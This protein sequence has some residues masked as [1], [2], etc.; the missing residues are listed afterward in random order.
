MDKILLSKSALDRY[1]FIG[2]IFCSLSYIFCILNENRQI[3]FANDVMMKSLGVDHVDLVLGKRFG[4]SFKCI[5][6]A[7]EVG[8]CGTSEHCRYC[9]A[10]ESTLESFRTRQKTMKE[11]RI[12]RIVQGKEF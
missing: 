9:G 3:V 1:P 5:H 7:D 12:R 8:G 11:C 10:I 2:E 4:E 6:S